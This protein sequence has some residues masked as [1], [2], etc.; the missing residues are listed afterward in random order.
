MKSRSRTHFGSVFLWSIPGILLIASGTA[1]L[2]RLGQAATTLGFLAMAAIGAGLTW[3]IWQLGQ[4]ARTVQQQADRT[5]QIARQLRQALEADE[6]SIPAHWGADPLEQ[7]LGRYTERCREVRQSLEAQVHAERQMLT[8]ER[9]LQQQVFRSNFLPMLILDS[10]TQRILHSN[11][12]AQHFYGQTAQE[13]RRLHLPQLLSPGTRPDPGCVEELIQGKSCQCRQ[14]HLNA[15]GE[16]CTMEAF[17]TLLPG[18][19]STLLILHDSSQQDRRIQELESRL[20][21]LQDLIENPALGMMRLDHQRIICMANQRLATMFGYNSPGELVGQHV[22]ILHLNTLSSQRF[23]QLFAQAAAHNQSLDIDYWGRRADGTPIRARVQG[24]LSTSESAP[25]SVWALQ[26]ITRESEIREELGASE[27]QYRTAF[28][29]SGIPALILATH[30]YDTPMPLQA[31]SACQEL[32]GMSIEQ[33]TPTP[34][35]DLVAPSERDDL[36]RYFDVRLRNGAIPPWHNSL[37]QPPQTQ[38]PIPVELRLDSIDSH[39]GMLS[40]QD[41]RPQMQAQTRYSAIFN[42]ASDLLLLLDI[43]EQ[44]RAT[45][46]VEANAAACRMLERPYAELLGMDIADIQPRLVQIPGLL[47]PNDALFLDIWFS[48]SD[49]Q[50]PMELALSLVEDGSRRHLFCSGRD[51]TERERLRRDKQRREAMM[52][53]QSRMAAMGEMLSAIAHQWR[54]PLNV[55]GLHLQCMEDDFCTGDLKPQE[56]SATLEQILGQL[57]FLGHTIDDFQ[58]FL[59]PGKSPE[60]FQ[61]DRALQQTLEL[62]GVLIERSGIDIR[63]QVDAQPSQLRVW[64][65]LNE[66][67]QVLLSLLLN[68]R[69]AIN[70]RNTTPRWIGL[71]LG[72]TDENWIELDIEDTGGGIPEDQL[73][74]VFDPYFTT[75]GEQGTG[76]G[77]SIARSILESSFMGT[78]HASNREHGACMHIRLPGKQAPI[79]DCSTDEEP[80][81]A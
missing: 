43:D 72:V 30:G 77:L 13:L 66:F 65:H 7:T 71:R 19:G 55:I 63:I 24:S 11:P 8:R 21:S 34:L 35:L 41:K 10:Q 48:T 45:R 78:V 59:Q 9:S 62:L 4:Q 51:Q 76:I 23:A 61:V 68:S 73:P 15:S 54:Q 14:V 70:S 32:L 57:E 29:N 2:A 53:Q 12:S 33:I 42:A 52:I 6:P 20:H 18:T 39:R 69:D 26:D 28:F 75:K 79:P 16:P 38:E 17:A 27:H 80:E 67:R 64:G 36:K 44:D 49:R 74:R 58:R 37:I 47:N 1:A 22:E 5:D 50:I 81:H 56:F 46:I 31:N 40:I 3:L 25:G 60:Y